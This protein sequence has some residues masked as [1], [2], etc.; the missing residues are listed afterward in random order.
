MQMK[1]DVINALDITNHNLLDQRQYD[2]TCFSQLS[3][4]TENERERENFICQNGFTSLQNYCN[5][6]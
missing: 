1:Y 3:G 4:K 5:E 6:V 2:K